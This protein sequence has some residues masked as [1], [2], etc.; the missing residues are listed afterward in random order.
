MSVLVNS[1]SVRHRGKP[2][3]RPIVTV[4][5]T[6]EDSEFFAEA[7]R[8]SLSV[9]DRTNFRFR[10]MR[11]DLGDAA[12]TDILRRFDIPGCRLS[13]VT[14]DRRYAQE[15]M[16]L[17]AGNEASV[18]WK[19]PFSILYSALNSDDDELVEFPSADESKTIIWQSQQNGLGGA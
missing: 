15:H 14:A 17:T 9:E 4:V 6:P 12:I 7:K 3:E 19:K 18:V 16:P 2:G 10:H 1:G 5:Y 11:R 13:V 8:F